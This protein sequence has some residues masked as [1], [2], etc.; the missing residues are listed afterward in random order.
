MQSSTDNVVLTSQECDHEAEPYTR[1]IQ[2]SES[3]LSAAYTD[4]EDES[5]AAD[6]PQIATASPG[7]RSIHDATDGAVPSSTLP[8]EQEQSTEARQPSRRW[9]AHVAP[10]SLTRKKKLRSP[11]VEPAEDGAVVVEYDELEV[12]RVAHQLSAL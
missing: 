5:S 10:T 6:C 11:L 8:D 2:R 9:A 3:N 4:P 1:L 12:V 7:S